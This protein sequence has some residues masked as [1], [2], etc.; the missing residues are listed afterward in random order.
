MK[1]YQKVA[2]LYFEYLR[3]VKE[4]WLADGQ[5]LELFNEMKLISNMDYEVFTAPD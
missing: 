3:Q 5:T 1:N 2:A 4:E